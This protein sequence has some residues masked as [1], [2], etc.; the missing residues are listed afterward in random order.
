MAAIVWRY[1]SL[2]CLLSHSADE[3]ASGS[4]G[5]IVGF[6]AMAGETRNHLG[7][8]ATSLARV[9]G[10][11]P[12]RQEHVR[13]RG[14]AGTTE[15]QGIFAATTSMTSARVGHTA[16]LLDSGA[17]L[18]PAETS[19]QRRVLRLSGRDIRS[20]EQHDLGKAVPSCDVADQRDGSH[21]RRNRR[22]Q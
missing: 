13:L 22:W 6:G 2:A 19:Q 16:T 9:E 8:G 15:L 7:G 11:R 4:G 17:S 3:Q 5:G 21:H 10:A 20:S 12:V 14:A 1:R 18:S